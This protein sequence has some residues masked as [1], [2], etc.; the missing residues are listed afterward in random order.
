MGTGKTT[1]IKCLK[2]NI[3]A[4]LGPD[5]PDDPAIGELIQIAAP[6]SCAAKLLP[7]PYSMLDLPVAKS[8][9]KLEPLSETTLKQVKEGLKHLVLLVIDKKSFLGAKMFSIIS[10]RMQQIFCRSET[11]FGGI[12]V[13]FMG[14]FAQLSPVSALF[15]PKTSQ[16][17][18]YGRVAPIP[19]LHPHHHPDSAAV[20]SFGCTV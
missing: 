1:L 4:T 7:S 18:C 5:D 16:H 20:S 19:G 14:D 3:A 12:S 6:T 13:L 10:H 15:Q 17:P 8:S 11:P 9:D 2:A